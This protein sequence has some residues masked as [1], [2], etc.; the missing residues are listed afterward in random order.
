M[1]SKIYDTLDWNK[2]KTKKGDTQNSERYYINVIKHELE[3][4]SAIVEQASSQQAIDFRIHLDNYYF[5]IE[6]KKIDSGKTFH[7][8]DTLPSSTSN[9]TYYM[10]FFTNSKTIKTIK[11]CD[12]YKTIDHKKNN[13]KNML[14]EKLQN[15]DFN[16]PKSLFKMFIETLL[17]HISLYKLGDMVK[18]TFYFGNFSMRPRPNWSLKVI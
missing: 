8:N 18:Q 11:S 3:K 15:N 17:P 14:I 12:L 6:C 2:V 5:E 10:F 7:L 16:N 4:M 9:N 1:E 13:S